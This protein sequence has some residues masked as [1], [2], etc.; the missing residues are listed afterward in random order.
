[1]KSKIKFIV[2]FIIIIMQ[3]NIINIYALTTEPYLNT[4]T[5]TDI[6][7]FEQYVSD[8]ETWLKGMTGEDGT[9]I[10]PNEIGTHY[11]DYYDKFISAINLERVNSQLNSTKVQTYS[12]II[13]KYQTVLSRFEEV[14]SSWE[15]A[16][17]ST[18]NMLGLNENSLNSIKNNIEQLRKTDTQELINQLDDD[19][20]TQMTKENITGAV[21][22][23]TQEKWEKAEKKAKDIIKKFETQEKINEFLKNSTVKEINEQRSEIQN[24]INTLKSNS[25][26]SIDADEKTKTYKKQLKKIRSEL[27]SDVSKKD[28]KE[29]NE[30]AKAKIKE[31][32]NKD[33][34]TYQIPQLTTGNK[35]DEKGQSTVDDVVQSGDDFLSQGAKKVIN[36]GVLQNI[37][38]SIYNILLS[39]S[40]ALMTI[41]GGIIGIQLMTASIEA[42]AKVKEYLVPYVVA[43][44][45]VF[46]GFTIWKIVVTILQQTI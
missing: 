25:G 1:M 18:L 19:E 46:G 41:I 3:I 29:I 34:E 7:N 45:I 35:E 43:C 4:Y 26:W 2:I 6:E 32:S 5:G 12:S 33:D 40:I 9:Y 42:K 23:E 37:S 28:Q 16:D 30:K 36:N 27:N 8:L 20:W 38:K 14:L 44:V 10:N 13:E 11:K 24:V 21:N 39:I 15:D 22:K 31:D 17:S